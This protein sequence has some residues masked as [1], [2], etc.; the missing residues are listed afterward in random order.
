MATTLDI[1]FLMK[2]QNAK[3]DSHQKYNQ[4]LNLAR[5]L[6]IWVSSQLCIQSLMYKVMGTAN[7]IKHVQSFEIH[8]QLKRN[9]IWFLILYGI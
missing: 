7:Y 5:A 8:I 2:D 6:I 3:R 9:S 4:T 1:V